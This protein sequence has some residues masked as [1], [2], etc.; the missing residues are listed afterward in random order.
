MKKRIISLLLVLTLAFIFTGCSSVDKELVASSAAELIEKSYEINNIYFGAGLPAVEYSGDKNANPKYSE[1]SADSPYQ[2]V[3]EIKEATLAVYSP[4]Y[5]E[6]LF[7][8]AFQGVSSTDSNNELIGVYY[9]RYVDY[10]GILTVKVPDEDEIMK[11]NRTYDT[12]H[13]TV[14]SGTSDRVA[15]SVPSF[16]D[17][18][19]DQDI[20]LTLV[21][22]ENGYR[23]DS[24]TY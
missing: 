11:L 13:I 18:V 17:G 7:N 22:T 16:V 9:A 6:Y 14:V 5:C 21:M 19:P 2:S 12:S 1:V 3:E 23:L 10:Y 8:L 4:D 24:P 20:K 15:I